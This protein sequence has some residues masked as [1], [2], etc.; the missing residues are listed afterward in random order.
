[1]GMQGCGR[2]GGEKGVLVSGQN[3]S[4]GIFSLCYGTIVGLGMWLVMEF[5]KA[6][7]H[8]LHF[9]LRGGSEV[10]VISVTHLQNCK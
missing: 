9:S 1:M 2:V 10:C 3:R 7:H 4:G 5:R 8:R 6:L